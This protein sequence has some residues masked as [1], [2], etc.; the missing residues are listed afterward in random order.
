MRNLAAA[1][2]TTAP[3]VIFRTF[4]AFSAICLS[5][6][7]SFEI[8]SRTSSLSTRPA[9]STSLHATSSPA[10]ATAS[11]KKKA[12]VVGAG[13][14]GIAAA[15]TLASAPHNYDVCL[16]ESSPQS[17]SQEKYD[18]TKAFLYNVNLRGQALTK[19]FPSM[20]RKLVERGVESGGFGG[21]ALT[22]VP[23][24]PNVPIPKRED[25][26]TSG[27]GSSREAKMEVKGEMG[28]KK[29]KE[30]GEGEEEDQEP[31]YWIPRHE[32]VQLM[33]EVLEEH[34]EQRGQLSGEG[35]AMGRIDYRP[36]QECV[37]VR[38]DEASSCVVVT[39]KDV[40]TGKDTKHAATLVVGAD[41]MNSRVRECL[42]TKD[43][44]AFS[45]WSNFNPK[46]FLPRKWRSPA[47]FQRIKV[48]QLPPRF[49]IPDGEFGELTTQSDHIYAI[50][51]IYN[52]PR[53]YLSLGLLPMKDN[54]AVRPTNIVT[55]PDHE[56]WTYKDG[57][58]VRQ[59]FEKAYP[60]LPFHK[61]GGLVS[62]E[63][64][65]RFA[66]AEGTRFPPCQYSPGMATC[67]DE[68]T[69]GVALVGD[70]IHAFPP[71]IG[72]GVNSGLADVVALDRSLRGLDTVTGEEIKSDASP[73]FKS[74]I[75]RY[76]KK[77]APEIAALIRLARFGA[78]FQYKQPHRVDRLRLKLWTAN[79][80]FRLLLN[81]L[82]FGLVPSQCIILS[83]DPKLTFRQ[84]MR[85]ADLTTVTIKA[86]LFGV[87]GLLLKRRFGLHVPKL[88][89]GFGLPVL[90]M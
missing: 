64:W 44:D 73:T 20:Q 88:P 79:V 61:D 77:H 43:S 58:S 86:I 25:G 1:T 63:E 87:L 40:S 72:Q 30:K 65:D 7:L 50:R 28:K 70:A 47:S 52:S 68:G 26:A 69:C 62:D 67:D 10:T 42:A 83:Q 27:G 49:K 29:K 35:E 75:E 8:P 78:P 18:P 60:R 9:P 38:P 24:D 17:T 4:L 76:Q 57:D 12:V 33:L 19:Q 71:D 53:K 6:A 74:N 66:K 34:E 37:S 48:L 5:D 54:D 85:K 14:V 46:K 11:T 82:T 56:I 45:H 55:R 81:K 41:G 84:V 36:G 31:S 16:L 80:V 13:P 15:L 3:I 23:A 89:Y 2:S 90:G 59:W 39:A 21:V 32:M 51:S 22:I